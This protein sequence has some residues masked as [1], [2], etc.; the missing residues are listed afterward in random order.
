M[1][2]ELRA[3]D[4]AQR[5]VQ[6]E[7]VADL[8]GHRVRPRPRPRRAR[9]PAGCPGHPAGSAPGP[10]PG[11]CP[12]GSSARPRPRPGTGRSRRARR[13]R[14]R[15][16]RTAVPRLSRGHV[17][18]VRV[19]GQHLTVRRRRD[20]VRGQRIGPQVHLVHAQPGRHRVPVLAVGDPARDP[21]LHG[22]L[23]N[24]ELIAQRGRRQ[25]AL[26]QRGSQPFV[27]HAPDRDPRGRP[28]TASP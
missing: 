20:L 28:G 26:K 14:V 2:P 18:A 17:R 12:R 23:V 24:A 13:S 8:R 25:A 19:D 4:L 3:L 7:R 21:A 11:P 22:L 10:R 6:H 5:P 15:L 1:E 16:P 27:R 9:P